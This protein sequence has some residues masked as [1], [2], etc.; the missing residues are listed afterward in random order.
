MT[1][2]EELRDKTYNSNVPN[3]VMFQMNREKEMQEK[4]KR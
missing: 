2:S 3:A 1:Q 4:S